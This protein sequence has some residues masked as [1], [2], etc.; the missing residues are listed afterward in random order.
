MAGGHFQLGLVP[1]DLDLTMI[2]IT[3]SDALAHEILLT[4]TH[5]Y[6][7]FATIDLT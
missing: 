6:G 2:D 1:T 3:G 7:R 4:P 5:P